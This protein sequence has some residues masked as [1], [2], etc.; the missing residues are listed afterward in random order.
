VTGP[1]FVDL[2]RGL[3]VVPVVVIDDV[4]HAAPLGHALRL[5]GLPCAEVT[6]RTDNALA[7]LRVLAEDPSLLVGAGTVVRPAQVGPAVEAGARYVVSPGFSAAVVAECAQIG[8]P[9]LPGVATATEIQ[10]ALEAGVQ[11]M[12][13]FPAEAAGGVAAVTALSAPFRDVTFV[14]TGGITAANLHDY[15]RVPSVAAVGGSWLVSPA[16]L[17]AEDFD[18][19]ASLVSAAVEQVRLVS[20]ASDAAVRSVGA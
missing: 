5:G 15:L 13:F 3:G 2:L 20:V 12:K 6:L 8:V 14:P 17:Q 16:L 7:C 18:T 11:T 1:A 9:V 4:R 19:I 10:A